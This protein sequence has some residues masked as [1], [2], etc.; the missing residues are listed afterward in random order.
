VTNF[1]HVSVVAFGARIV[2]DLHKN[3]SVQSE[4]SVPNQYFI[5]E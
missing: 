3:H 5:M 4:V 1:D 2:C